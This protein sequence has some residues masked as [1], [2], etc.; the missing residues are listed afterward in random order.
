MQGKTGARE[1]YDFEKTL[2]ERMLQAEREIVADVMAASTS[3]P[4]RSRSTVGSS[5]LA[6]NSPPLLVKTDPGLDRVSAVRREVVGGVVENV[7]ERHDP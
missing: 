1:F 5:P 6:K 7:R 4:T 2:H 3:T